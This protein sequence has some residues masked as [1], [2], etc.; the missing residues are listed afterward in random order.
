MK[1][2]AF[3]AWWCTEVKFRAVLLAIALGVAAPAA[4]AQGAPEAT[5]ARFIELANAGRLTSPEGQAILTG[6][7]KQMATDAASNLPAADRIVPVSPDLVAARIVLQ[8]PRGLEADAYFYLER[9][10]TGWA[11]SAYRAMAM[12]GM[13]ISLLSELKRRP[14]LSA[15]EET[16]RRNLELMLST[17]SQLRAWFTANRP[18][19][20]TI[21]KAWRARPAEERG[22]ALSALGLSTIGAK[23]DGVQMAIGS[24]LG[25]TAGFLLAGSSG[26]PP[27]SPSGYFWVEP[28][29]G[30]WFLF[31]TM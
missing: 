17:D 9:V 2:R 3:A 24:K 8:G 25:N 11:V 29:G 5:L 19:L 4:L 28:L 31:R 13:D 23:G 15:E 27:I 12:T 20:E 6:E 1:A 26:P 18:A 14:N 10:Q 22:P 30:G 21:A 16:L 7:A